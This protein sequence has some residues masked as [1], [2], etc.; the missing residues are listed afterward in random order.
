MTDP[1]TAWRLLM[2]AVTPLPAAPR[3]PGDC[4]HGHLAEAVRADRD[5]P[6]A[7]R[8]AMDGYAVR[9]ADTADAPVALRL[10]GE[11]AAGSPSGPAVEAGTCVRI[12]TGA[13]IP[14]GADAVVRIEDTEARGAAVR[15]S[16]A[17]GPGAH[18]LRRAE[19]ARAG[20]EVLPRGSRLDPAALALCSAVGC[21]MPLVHARPRVAIVVTGSEIRPA[22]A[23][24]GT[25]ELR[26]A[27]GPLIAATLA[28]QG[29]GRTP[30]EIV[31]DDRDRLL[32]QLRLAVAGC[33]VTLVSGGVSVGRYDFVP[34]VVAAL[35][36]T[37]RYHGLAMKP[38]KPQ[39]F[40]TFGTDRHLFGLPGNPLA[41]L[42]GLHEFALPA[43]RRLAGCPEDACRPLL[44]LPLL[45]DA[46]AAGGRRTY[47]IARLVT[48]AGG[49]G[50]MPLP[51]SGSS[52]FVAGC[53]ADGM[54]VLPAGTPSLPAGALVDFRPWRGC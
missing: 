48:T 22:A 4:L 47:L 2:D 3:P 50:V 25:H 27:N 31:P 20:D 9:A 34:E 5:I 43:L 12:M 15:L 8:A 33:E 19:N 21:T 46:R 45:R 51:H 13:N 32:E 40:A 36:G 16:R 52:D 38:G 28:A 17:V 18:I 30:W 26:D 37:I 1:E 23:A 49:T 44:R 29:L 6:A 54:A 35:G 7:D 42:N 39:L 24:V 14:P 10:C 41:V 11:V 53:R